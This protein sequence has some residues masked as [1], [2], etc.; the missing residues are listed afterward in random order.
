MMDEPTLLWGGLI[1]FFKYYKAKISKYYG[2]YDLICL[3][4]LNNKQV[5]AVLYVLFTK[6]ATSKRLLVVSSDRTFK[7]I[8][9][10]EIW[11]IE[12][13]RIRLQERPTYR[14]IW[15]CQKWQA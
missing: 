15:F 14:D 10:T 4:I 3:K 9:P 6:F 7:R 8:I 11:K 1:L 12:V 13:T 5:L 2:T